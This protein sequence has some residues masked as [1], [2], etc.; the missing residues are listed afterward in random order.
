MGCE[1]SVQFRLLDITHTNRDLRLSLFLLV[2]YQLGMGKRTSIPIPTYIPALGGKPDRSGG[3]SGNELDA[4]SVD[5]V[6]FHFLLLPPPQPQSAITRLANHETSPQTEPTP[7]P[8]LPLHSS[9]LPNWPTIETKS[10]V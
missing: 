9:L 4:A 6:S 1:W 10:Q 7:T 5:A 2:E 8:H 3:W